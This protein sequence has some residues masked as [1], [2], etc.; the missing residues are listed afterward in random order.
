MR[1]I[2]GVELDG[3]SCGFDGGLC[4]SKANGM[5]LFADAERH[6]HCIL[7]IDGL[8][9]NCG[10]LRSNDSISN[11]DDLSCRTLLST[12]L[13]SFGARRLRSTV[14][15]R[16]I[17]QNRLFALR[18]RSSDDKLQQMDVSQLKDYNMSLLDV[19]YC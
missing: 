5:V 18:P 1:M 10:A 14:A 15:L 8:K 11:D 9:D 3:G 6:R 2:A 16:G 17:L 7:I 4:R 12:G 19:S 13:V